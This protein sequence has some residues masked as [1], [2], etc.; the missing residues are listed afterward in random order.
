MTGV[1]RPALAAAG[2]LLSAASVADISWSSASAEPV[3][4]E[5]VVVTAMRRTQ[6]LDTVPES[7]GVLTAAQIRKRH[8]R[9]IADAASYVPGVSVDPGTNA[10]SI[11]GIASGA[12][13]GVTGIYIDDVP[14][15]MRTLD[16]SANDTLPEMFDLDRIEILR[17]PQGTL[18]GAGSE[19][20]AVRYITRQPD[21]TDAEGYAS[22]EVSADGVGSAS[23]AL[24]GAVGMPIADRAALR[25]SGWRRTDGGTVDAF[26]Y[27]TGRTARSDA[28]GQ[29]SYAVRA[30][31]GWTPWP[32]LTVTLS[33]YL[34]QRVKKGSDAY[35]VAASSLAGDRLRSGTPEAL[36]D[37]DHFNLASL[38]AVYALDGAE[39]VSNTSYFTRLEHVQGYSGTLYNL[40]YFQQLLAA[41]TDPMGETCSGGQCVAGLYPLLT[42]T[43]IDLPGFGRYRSVATI[44]NAQRNFVEEVRLQSSDPDARLVWLAGV[45]YALDTQQSIDEV[46]DP[47]LPD[48]T[49]YLWGEDILSAWGEAL[50]P[51]GDAF[52]NDTVAHDHQLAF[53]ANAAYS[54]VDGVKLQGGIRVAGTGFD[55]R[56]YSDGPENFGFDSGT[57]REAETPVTGMA[58]LSY[59]FDDG[60]T[61]YA[62]FANGYR[63][64]GANAPF[65]EAS[66]EADLK[67]LGIDHVPGTFGSDSVTSYE[68]GA[69]GG[70]LGGRLHYAGSAFVARW[71]QI[72]QANYLSS[73]GFQYVANLGSASSAGFDLEIDWLIDDDLRA[74][75]SVGYTDAHFTKDSRAGTN[76]KAA[77]IVRKGDAL[78]GSP[79]KLSAGIQYDFTAMRQPFSLRFDD[80]FASRLSRLTPTTDPFTSQYDPGL[81]ADPAVNLAALR[82]TTTIRST[83]LSLF[84]DNLFD[85]RPQLGLTHQDAFTLLYEAT[86]LRPRTVGMAVSYSY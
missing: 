66:C 55:F 86:T 43:G 12:G 39:L 33:D 53:F 78:A 40:S 31:A 80:T 41:G 11:R 3:G 71:D 17:G 82:L 18:F 54:V 72:Q 45:F 52:I 9:T 69:K 26:D 83:E 56:N 74:N 65:P 64:G 42:A 10:V 61:I 14:I 38:K 28:N 5:T 58:S 50:L 46:N 15:Q 27:L 23:Y 4:L 37:R 67:Q 68:L 57:G 79:W 25:L 70:L 62:T 19:G 2:M 16:F 32:R 60:G 6:A 34:Q 21:M 81:R 36:A 76:S 75:V 8:I 29:D 84:V 51:N 7:V 30:A 59:A 77:V 22:A 85:S 13:A 47:Q 20:G 35:W 63:I 73:C 44:T 1:P 24:G 48:M 49:R